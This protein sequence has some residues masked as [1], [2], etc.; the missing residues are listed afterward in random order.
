M[1]GSFGVGGLNSLMLV[2]FLGFRSP[3]LYPAELRAQQSETSVVLAS[4]PTL[5]C[6]ICFFKMTGEG[7]FSWDLNP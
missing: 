6:R 5:A 2:L 4:C 3:A 7:L 1:Q